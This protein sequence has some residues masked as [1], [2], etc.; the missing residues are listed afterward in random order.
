MLLLMSVVLLRLLE[1]LPYVVLVNYSACLCKI[2]VAEEVDMVLG[3]FLI[4]PS[5]LYYLGLKEV[6]LILGVEVVGVIG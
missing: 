3:A 1:P 2:F 4:P 5:I 6:F